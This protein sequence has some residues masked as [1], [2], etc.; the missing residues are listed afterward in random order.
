MDAKL[1]EVID[2][3]YS[4]KREA[5]RRALMTY[6]QRQ[7][8]AADA[9]YLL[10]WAADTPEERR[11]AIY[12]ALALNPDELRYQKRMAKLQLAAPARKK[13]PGAARGKTK[14]S[15]SGKATSAPAAHKAAS[16]PAKSASTSSSRTILI[17][18]VLLLVVLFGGGA[19]LLA[20]GMLNG[21]PVAALPTQAVLPSLEPELPVLTPDSSMPDLSTET[22]TSTELPL[23][24]SPEPSATAT[25]VA[26]AT[27][28]PLPTQTETSTTEPEPVLEATPTAETLAL[29]VST[30][31]A[32]S[33]APVIIVATANSAQLTT[34]PVE[35][36][37]TSTPEGVIAGSTPAQDSRPSVTPQ[38]G[39]FVPPANTVR[40]NEAGQVLGGDLRVLEFAVPANAFLTEMGITPSGLPAG[41]R[42][43]LMEVSLLCGV[44][45]ECSPLTSAMVLVGSSGTRYQPD[46]TLPLDP[47]FGPEA[48]LGGQV[49]GYLAYVV[50]ANEANL[51]L[52]V[53]SGSG[54]LTFALR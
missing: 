14:S 48:N 20:S 23:S 42:W 21:Q 11:K 47:I 51:W 1:K 17:L 13:N 53:Q 8:R 6:I 52:Q 2:L 46:L 10:S 32:A 4:G 37:A 18:L 31:I 19:L 3:L 27:L 35:V 36:L 22:P 43:A 25:F 38:P 5:A 49:W 12:R 24:P 39:G 54:S 40:L 16:V 44:G 28:E 9:W 33:P 41:Q 26:T 29:S 34:Q 45:K 7:P 50:S 30:Q 15:T